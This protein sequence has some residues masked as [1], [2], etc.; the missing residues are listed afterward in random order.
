MVFCE[1]LL[2]SWIAIHVM[3]LPLHQ[4]S[5]RDRTM[6]THNKMLPRSLRVARPN[7]SYLHTH[8]TQNVQKTACSE[9]LSGFC[10][11]CRS[12]L[13]PKPKRLCE[14]YDV[15]EKSVGAS[16]LYNCLVW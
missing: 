13:N 9:L 15:L 8:F 10:H 3:A 6:T 14:V 1:Q 11:Q 5:S 7:L 4:F 12:A 16:T 2:I